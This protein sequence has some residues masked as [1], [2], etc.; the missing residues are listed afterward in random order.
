MKPLSGMVRNFYALIFFFR[1]KSFSLR[2][3]SLFSFF[4]S[5]IV[6]TAGCKKTPTVTDVIAPTLATNNVIV[7]LTTTSAQSGGVITSAGGGTI[8]KNGV[9]Y[10]STD[11]TP[12]TSD[13]KTSD[14]VSTANTAIIYFNSYLTG[15]TPNTTYYLRAYAANSAGTS[16]GGVIK[17]TTS[18]TLTSITATVSTF[19]GTGIAG[20]MDGAAGSAL[21]NNPQ[22]VSVDGKGDVYV[23]D[24][25][26]GFIREV[27]AGGN[28][29][30]IAGNQT[31]GYMNGP[32]LSA[33]FYA[34]NGQAFDSQ[35]NLYVS[36]YGN[37]VIRK[38]TPAGVVSLY[39]GVPGVAGYRNGAVD[40]AKLTGIADSLAM[41][42]NPQGIAVD[43]AGD[44]FVAD[45]GNNVI[46]EILP[47][48]RTK[49]IAGA[50]VK[51]FIDGLDELAFFN[52]PTGVAVDAQGNVYVTDQGNSALRK[53]TPAG[54]VSTLAGNPT[55]TSLLNLPSA[56]TIDSK[57]NLYIVDEGGRIIEYTTNNV[58][59]NL[60]GS[61][62]TNGFANGVG[63][64]ASFNNPQGIAVDANGNIY[65]ADQ[66]NNCIRKLVVTTTLVN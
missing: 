43:A 12:T 7:N 37:N 26:N 39:A 44:V 56:I 23:S 25:Y 8:T 54:E 1:M 47:T 11:Q 50:F 21:F 64:F 49:T 19:A 55:A 52:E 46:R 57:G 29:S 20:Y 17:F 30:T 59:Y 32:A 65:V 41:F 5:I 42:R 51:G 2:N 33:E 40:S 9:C 24:T 10:S 4:L 22:G 62:N 34:P 53:I 31:I 58:L 45:R 18:S 63:P 16:Y 6:L 3:I 14:S 15:L 60:A 48:G 13:S 27:S 35:G 36:D 66:Y 28:V 61:A 38:I